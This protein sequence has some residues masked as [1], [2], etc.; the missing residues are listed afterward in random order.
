MSDFTE[1][2]VEAGGFRIRYREAGSGQP[3]VT[4]HG[5]GGLRISRSHQLLS[6]HCHVMAMECPGFGASPVNERTKSIQEMADTMSA[7]ITALG[8]DRCNLMGNSFGGR[9][10][11]WL[12][13]RHPEQIESLIL[14]APAAIKLEG[15]KPVAPADRLGL[16]YAHPERQPAM[17]KP[18][19][20][21]LA[22]QEALLARLATPPRDPDLERRMAD[23]TMPVLVMFGTLDRMFPTEVGRIYREKIP[24]SNLVFVYDAGH[25]LDADRPEAFASLVA[26]FLARRQGFLVPNESKL[27]NP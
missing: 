2:F 17:P 6:E 5:A 9:L 18:A 23:L 13:I 21:V 4:I 7:A 8:L 27:I 16:L 20:E 12:A 11:L 1:K 15:V 26:D 19:P 22:K 14:V 25:A 10:S 3:L 24:N